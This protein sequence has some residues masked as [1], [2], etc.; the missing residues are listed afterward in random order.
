M[1][2]RNTGSGRE[3]EEDGPRDGGREREREGKNEFSQL[4]HMW[5]STQGLC[6]IFFSLAVKLS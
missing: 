2:G 4:E 1:V 3:T 6:P 5:E